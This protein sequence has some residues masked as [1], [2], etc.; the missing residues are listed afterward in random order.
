M[1]ALAREPFW[2]SR[3][4]KDSSGWQETLL[5]IAVAAVC[6]DDRDAYYGG[7]IRGRVGRDGFRCRNKR[8]KA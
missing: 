5:T 4:N 6:K 7:P 8:K 1:A 2:S 3:R